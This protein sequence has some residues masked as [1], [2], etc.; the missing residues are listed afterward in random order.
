MEYDEAVDEEENSKAEK[1][2]SEFHVYDS[3]EI[4]ID[5]NFSQL[6]DFSE[7]E[8][9]DEAKASKVESDEVELSEQEPVDAIVEVPST[10]KYRCKCGSFLTGWDNYR[11]H[12]LRH[13]KSREE[14][15]KCKYCP[16]QF[17][18]T[19]DLNFHE[20]QHVQPKKQYQCDNCQKNYSSA[21]SLKKHKK[22]HTEN[23]KI[24]KC[25]FPDCNMSFSRK[26]T[27]QNH[28]LLHD[29]SNKPFVCTRDNCDEAFYQKNTLQRHL[30]MAHG[31][32]FFYECDGCQMGYAKKAEL[33]I[34]YE[35]CDKFL[36]TRK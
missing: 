7:I 23:F 15:L 4:E 22:I 6:D 8:Q 29:A 10:N 21:D 34:H 1:L 9:I 32:K 30:K 20:K 19:R 16:R 13:K 27:L 5:D 28:I 14:K 35:S 3:D 11:R 12:L 24:F 26:Y 17:V 36:E 18:F 25:N 33:K 2:R 31:Q